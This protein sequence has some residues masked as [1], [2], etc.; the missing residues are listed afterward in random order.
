MID[1]YSERSIKLGVSFLWTIEG[2]HRL[3]HVCREWIAKTH[4]AGSI[5]RLASLIEQR[6]QIK[7]F[8][9]ALLFVERGDP[10]MRHHR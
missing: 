3:P 5:L 1:E 9:K 4:A 6:V 7:R 2:L 10:I 8:S